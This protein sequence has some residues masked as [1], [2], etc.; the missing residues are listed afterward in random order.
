MKGHF[1]PIKE[2]FAAQ[3]AR[4]FLTWLEER[5]YV[6]VLQ[7]RIALD[8]E[9]L[10][11]KKWHQEICDTQGQIFPGKFVTDSF[12]RLCIVT[13]IRQRIEHALNLIDFGGDYGAADYRFRKRLMRLWARTRG[14]HTKSSEA[15]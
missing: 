3:L 10:L 8:Q 9:F 7:F 5:R 11:E 1:N 4:E 15:C 6:L 2:A 14:K 13:F 12:K